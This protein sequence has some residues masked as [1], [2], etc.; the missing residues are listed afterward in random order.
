MAFDTISKMFNGVVEKYSE[1]ELY[2]YK[3]D[4]EWIGLKGTVIQATVE[5]IA[6]GLKSISDEQFNSAI[7]SAN[8][9]RWAMSDY[10]IIC[11]GG[12]TVSIY[13]TLIPSQIEFILNDSQ[14]KVVF[15]EN[16]E[17][18]EKVLEIKDNCPSLEK[19]I[20]LD[21][22]HDSS[23]EEILNF[24]DFLNIGNEVIKKSDTSF[25]DLINVANEDDLLTLIYMLFYFLVENF[26]LTLIKYSIKLDFH[27]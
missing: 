2:F 8:S 13:P 10:G 21:D 9:P 3:H 7:L 4:N 26:S 11:S 27:N 22:S 1:K 6:F 16:K 12:C 15:V 25:G 19:I 14:S 5:E 17:Q 18:K 20:V 24:M 23:N